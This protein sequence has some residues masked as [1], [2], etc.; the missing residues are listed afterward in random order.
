MPTLDKDLAPSFLMTCSAREERQGSLTVQ[1]APVQELGTLTPAGDI[2]MMLDLN[3]WRVCTNTFWHC[4]NENKVAFYTF[5]GYSVGCCITKENLRTELCF[6]STYLHYIQNVVYYD[7]CCTRHC[8]QPV[9]ME[10]LNW[11]A[12]PVTMR[13]VWRSALMDSGALCVMIIG[14]LWMLKWLADS[15]GFQI[16]VWFVSK[17]ICA[18]INTKVNCCN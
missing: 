1:G 14:D 12:G 15:L 5:S 7:H 10:K 18:M 11:W 16:L 3:V 13:A 2:L 6:W 4:K 17:F 9:L 8:L